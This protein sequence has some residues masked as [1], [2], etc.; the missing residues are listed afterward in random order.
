MSKYE[1][2]VPTSN[3]FDFH[4]TSIEIDIDGGGGGQAVL[5]LIKE[6]TV[7]L[8]NIRLHRIL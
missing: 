4:G 5:T 1:P 7:P 6:G 3:P 8:Q 2:I